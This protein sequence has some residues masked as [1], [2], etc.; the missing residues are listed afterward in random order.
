[1]TATPHGTCEFTMK[2][3]VSRFTSAAKEAANFA[4][5]SSRKPSCGGRIGGTG[6]PGAGSLIN[7][8]I[9]DTACLHP[10]YMRRRKGG[11]SDFAPS[12]ASWHL[13]FD[14][15]AAPRP[16]AEGPSEYIVSLHIAGQLASREPTVV[17]SVEA[18]MRKAT[19]SVS[20]GSPLAASWAARQS[21]PARCVIST[22]WLLRCNHHEYRVRH[23]NVEPA[24]AGR[25]VGAHADLSC[26]GNRRG[27]A[28]LSISEDHEFG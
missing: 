17:D 5:S 14:P 20:D 27:R 12:L 25:S 26:S 6:A 15:C 28:T 21:M 8:P 4:L 3:A 24:A 16:F 1:M 9:D 18:E 23:V 7:D 11:H 19:D 22:F 10:E 2:V 13:A